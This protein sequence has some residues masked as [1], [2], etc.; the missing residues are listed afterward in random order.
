MPRRLNIYVQNRR[1]SSVHRLEERACIEDVVVHGAELGVPLGTIVKTL[2]I[3]HPRIPGE[4]VQAKNFVDV[5]PVRFRDALAKI[6]NEV[7]ERSNWPP[8]VERSVSV[9]SNQEQYAP[10]TYDPTPFLQRAQRV[11]QVFYDMGCEKDVVGPRR[12]APEVGRLRSQ[13]P[14]QNPGGQRGR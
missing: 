11:R 9:R 12:K 8:V 10:K 6:I 13:H 3:L 5:R 1:A 14:A 7:R 2:R 4:V